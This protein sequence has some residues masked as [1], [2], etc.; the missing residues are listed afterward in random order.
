[1]KRTLAVLLLLTNFGQAAPPVGFQA[2]VK[3]LGPTALDWSFVASGFPAADAKVPADFDS[4]KQSFQLYVPANYKRDRAWP[5]VVFVSPGDAPMGWRSWQKVCESRGLLYCEAYRAGNQVP[6]GRRVRIVLDVLSQVRRDYTIDP[7]RTYVSGFSGGGRIACTLGYSL[8]EVFGGIVP[9]CGTNPLARLDY[10]RHRAQ[11]RLSVAFV[12][13]E[14]DFNR[15]ENEK[16]MMPFVKDVGIRT[17]LWVVQ[18]LGHAVPGEAILSETV[19]W[20]DEDLPRRQADVKKRPGLAALA[21]NGLKDEKLAAGLL[22]TA[23]AELKEEARVW[24]GVTLLQGILAR[25]PRTQA[26]AKARARLNEVKDDE[27]LLQLVG[28]QGGLEARSFLLAQAQAFER[29]EKKD[30]AIQAYKMLTEEYPFSTEGRKAATELRRLTGKAAPPSLGLGFAS[31]SPVV[32]QVVPDSPADK[33][34]V[35]PGD[36]ILAIDAKKVRSLDEVRAALKD[37]KPGDQVK[38]TLD[39]KGMSLTLTLQA[40]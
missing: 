34:G 17:R 33:A 7:D 31:E 23:E 11:D 20:L 6:A 12:T 30:A 21:E 36:R 39:R 24:R 16:Y 2:N 13:G 9:I 32:E 28:D 29:F 10:L 37:I 38:L 40:Q 14:K 4:T 22:E 8:P 26:G 25:F 1:M 35:Q 27:R 15:L 19:K 18:G 3:V 5:L